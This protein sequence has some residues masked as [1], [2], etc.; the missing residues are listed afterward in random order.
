LK[1]E[2]L[3]NEKK[4]LQ[5]VFNAL[6]DSK[7]LLSQEN[8]QLLSRLAKMV[9]L[10]ENEIELITNQVVT[11]TPMEAPYSLTPD[12][13]LLKLYDEVERC[14]RTEN[15]SKLGHT[16]QLMNDYLEIDEKDGYFP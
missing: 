7:D 4:R 13:I 11:E 15:T 2:D 5:I 8:Q 9:H 1:G 16:R 10:S 3:L 6:E 14:S 12:Q